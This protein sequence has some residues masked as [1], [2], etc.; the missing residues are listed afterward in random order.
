MKKTIVSIIIIGIFVLYCF[1]HAQTNPVAVVPTATPTSRSSSS[2]T[3][4][5]TSTAA[6]GTTPTPGATS[7]SGSTLK[8]GTYTGNTADAQWG[9][10]QIQAVIQNGKISSVQFFAISQRA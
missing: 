5:P 9:V 4:A 10:V 3:P 7:T 6:P 8:N 2:S 1:V